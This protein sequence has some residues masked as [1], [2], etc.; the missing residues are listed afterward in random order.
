MHFKSQVAEIL[1]AVREVDKESESNELLAFTPA[2]LFVGKFD[3][4]NEDQT[5]PLSVLHEVCLRAYEKADADP[6]TKLTGEKGFMLLVDV[7]YYPGGDTRTMPINI[8]FVYL[9]SDQVVSLSLGVIPQ[10][11]TRQ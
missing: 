3:S 11:Q 7:R 6:E 9:F 2:G 5:E 1:Y 4:F 10:S 8:P